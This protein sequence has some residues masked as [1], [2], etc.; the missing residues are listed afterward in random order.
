MQQRA[1]IALAALVALSAGLG[2]ALSTALRPPL[3]SEVSSI[4]MRTGSIAPVLSIPNSALGGVVTE[5]CVRPGDAVKV[6][7]ILVR[8][9][10]QELQ[11]R[12]REIQ[13]A[14]LSVDAQLAG[15]GVLDRVPER[16]KRY[17]YQTHPDVVSAEE[18]Y[19]RALDAWEKTSGSRR[20]EEEAKLTA[21]AGQRTLARRRLDQVLSTSAGNGEMQLVIRNLRKNRAE[22]EQLLRDREVRA[23]VN[24]FVDILDL[25]PGD[26]MFPRSPLATIRVDGEYAADVILPNRDASRVQRGQII[27]GHVVNGPAVQ[28][29][30]ELVSQLKIAAAFREQRDVEEDTVVHL[31]FH[32]DRSLRA[33]SPAQFYLP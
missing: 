4:G 20:A 8:L 18:G 12:L 10:A 15:R 30:V 26:K 31:R 23:D 13:L 24:G 16:L 29:T 14:E 2:G 33:G 7:Q 22:L 28:A 3:P 9:N 21:A 6:G 11:Q 25:K 1:R 32:S 27:P 19:V 5:V 17:I